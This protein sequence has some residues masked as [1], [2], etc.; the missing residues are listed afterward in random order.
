MD[1]IDDHHEYCS[2]GYD[3]EDIVITGVA[4]RFPECH[5][6]GELFEGLMNKKQLIVYSDERFEKGAAKLPFSSAGV[7]SGLDKFDADYFCVPYEAVNAFDP[8]TRKVIEISYEAIVDSGFDPTSLRGAK[9]GVYNAT[10]NDDSQ[11]L[12]LSDEKKLT[13]FSWLRCLHANRVSYAFDFLGPS[14]SVDTACSSSAVAIWAA[15]KDLVE[16]RVEAAVVNA[17]QL[18]MN[19]NITLAYLKHGI[20]SPTGCNSMPFDANT[21]GMNRTEAV[22]AIFIQKAKHARRVYA[23]ISSAKFVTSGY[24]PEGISVP[25]Q[26]M[27]IQLSQEILS[28]NGLK[29]DDIDYFEGHGTGS[30]V[31]DPIELNAIAQVYCKNGRKRP[32]YVGSVKSNIGHTEACAGLC[33]IIKTCMALDRGMI[34]PNYKWSTPNSLCQ[35]MVEG[36]VK[37][38]TEPMPVVSQYIPV[39]SFGLAG[40]IVQI[41][42]RQHSKTLEDSPNKKSPLPR[43]LLYSGTVESAVQYVFDYVKDNPNLPDEFFALLHKLSFCPTLLKPIRGYA[44]YKDQSN[45]VTSM[46]LCLPNKR[47]VWYIYTG[48]GCQWQGMGLQLMVFDA[49]AKSLRR[50][51]E[52]LKP[53]GIDLFKDL[54]PDTNEMEISRRGISPVTSITAIQIAMTDLLTSLGIKPDGIIGHSTGECASA[55]GDGSATLEETLLVAYFR[56]FSAEQSNLEHGAM[57]AV[58]LSW[59]ETMKRCPKD[60]FA[61]CHNAND[62]TTISGAEDAVK[63]FAKKLKEERIFVRVFDSYGC[64]LHCPLI[65]PALKL[66]REKLLQVFTNPK[67]RSSKWISS[68]YPENEWGTEECKYAGADYFT[69][70]M[71][72]PVLFRDAMRKIPSDAI[73]IEIGPHHLLQPIMRRDLGSGSSYIGLMRRNDPDNAKF[74]FEAIGKMYQEGMDPKVENLYPPVQFPVPRGVPLISDLIRWNYSMSFDVPKWSRSAGTSNHIFA[75]DKE[76]SYLMDHFI[77]GR[78]LFPAAGYIYLAWDMLASKLQKN[79]NEMPVIIENF[80]IHRATVITQKSMVKFSFTVFSD[81]GNFEIIESNQLVASGRVY[82]WEKATFLEPEPTYESSTDAVDASDIYNELKMVGYEYKQ[83]FQALSEI[84]L[85]GTQ[86]LL[87]W[88]DRWIPFLDALLLFFGLINNKGD[89]QLP[90]GALSFKIDPRL[91]YEKVDENSEN[92]EIKIPVNYN[93][94][95]KICR[96]AGIEI[97]NLQTDPAPHRPKD[98]QPTLEEYKFIPYISDFTPGKDLESKLLKYMWACNSLIDDIGIKQK[99]DVRSY[100]FNIGSN[101]DFRYDNCRLSAPEQNGLLRCL[102]DI[103]GSSFDLKNKKKE[104]LIQFRKEASRDFLNTIMATEYPLRIMM[105]ILTENTFGKL[106][107]LE[108]NS[109]GFAV[110]LPKIIDL[111]QKYSHM[112]FRSSI[113]IHSASVEVDVNELSASNIHSQPL[114]VL[115]NYAKEK[116]QDVVIGSFLG[117]SLKELQSCVQSLASIVKPEGFVLF[118]VKEK[119]LPAENL[120]L[121]LY[122]EDI[123]IHTR[124]TTE[125]VFQDNNLLVVSKIFDTFSTAVYLLRAP[126]LHPSYKVIKVTEDNKYRWVDDVKKLLAASETELLWLVAE[127]TPVNGIVGMVNC[128]KQEPGGERVKC[129]FISP[130]SGEKKPPA[131]SFDHALY[132]GLLAGNLTMN[133]WRDGSWGSFKHVLLGNQ[134]QRK[135]VDHSYVNCMKYRDLSSFEWIESHV[136][137]AEMKDSKLVHIYYSAL[138]FKDV[139][140]ATGRLSIG[141]SKSINGNGDDSV[142]G[143]E[144]SGKDESGRRVAGVIANRGMATSTSV[145]PSCLIEV[146]HNWSLEEASTVPVVYAT[147]YYALIIRAQLKRGEKVLIHSGTG[148][149]GIAAINIALGLGCEVFTT[150]G[151]DD[152]RKYLRKIFPQ[153]KEE[154]IGCSRNITFENMVMKRTKGK[155]VDVVLNSLAGDKFLASVRCVAKHGRFIEIGKYDL[156]LDRQL[157]LKHFLENI[158]FHGVFLDQLFDRNAH[159]IEVFNQIIQL[160]REG[161]KSGIVKPLDRKVF[162]RNEVEKA[163]KYMAKGIHVGKVVLKIRDEEPDKRAVPKLLTLPAIPNTYFYPAKVYIIIG[164]LGGF[165]VEVTKWIL[166]RGGRNVIL[167]SRYGARTSYQRLCLRR[168]KGMGANVQVLTLNAAIRDEAE[169]LVKEASKVGAVGGIFNSAV[170]LKDAFMETQTPMQFEEVCAPKAIATRYLDEFSRKYC[171]SIDYFVCFSSISCGRGIAGQTNYG[172]A[173]SVMER[174]CERRRQDGLSGLAIQWGIIGEVGG[175]HRHMGD[176][177]MIAGV[178]AQSVK[179]CLDTMDLFCQEDHP[180]VCSYMAAT[181]AVKKGDSVDLMGQITKILG[182]SGEITEVMQQRSLGEMGLDSL[183]AVEFGNLLETHFGSSLSMQEVFKMKFSDLEQLVREAQETAT[184]SVKPSSN[185]VSTTDIKL[186][187]MTINEPVFQLTKFTAGIPVVIVNIGN[188]DVG[189]FSLLTKSF[190]K[191][192]YTLQWTNNIEA[193]NMEELAAYFLK[194]IKPK[195]RGI[196]HLIGY[197]MGS[198]LAIEMAKQDPRSVNTLTLLDG[199]ANLLKVNNNEINCDPEVNSLLKFVAQFS[200]IDNNTLKDELIKAETYEQRVKCVT[201][202]L[203]SIDSMNKDELSDAISQFVQKDKIIQSYIPSGRLQRDILL[204]EDPMK[205]LA[206]DVTKIKRQFSQMVSGKVTVHR[207]I[208]EKDYTNKDSVSKLVKVLCD[209]IF[210]KEIN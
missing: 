44:L 172:Y 64:A 69:H 9:I 128:L 53:F 57:A 146:P 93:Q 2:A 153:V 138:N 198:G 103:A 36:K 136:K 61:A 154:N 62:S 116:D 199:T 188:T 32:M 3:P 203:T 55:Y 204:I 181:T 23:K 92:F 73:T 68:S 96:S 183:L 17:C 108:V 29:P 176:N 133:I 97:I 195:T 194:L 49:Y 40:T 163:F 111:M 162:Q 180:V 8:A 187:S 167:T 86:G 74:F 25:S 50:C 71:I 161:I 78:A 145:H 52:V 118:Y 80:K 1:F 179:S 85:D 16:N 113:L 94:D 148:G 205:T 171:P 37:V 31:G 77:D 156:S 175:V 201:N 208:S 21:D 43:F 47:P 63:N 34:P 193:N 79:F 185:L 91:L 126:G 66:L 143:L 190:E 119:H 209:E 4:G 207:V 155:G 41:L 83:A 169:Q 115:S 54:S 81:S 200:S 28:E 186:P 184:S 13:G 30:H 15:M 20:C 117:G 99:T 39:N 67:E 144:F 26:K 123:P 19:P 100:K 56:C 192:F 132:K 12:T 151:N 182:I 45:P 42:L 104:L 159:N 88:E 147:G 18:D 152:K 122:G 166:N 196:F 174:V 177:A 170:V 7:I 124:L 27:Q 46:K 24:V 197:S 11:L 95:T 112:K 59:E 75:L 6:V 137:Y 89:F 14:Y 135:T 65:K 48:M 142:L 82:E 114:D 105:E 60:V 106:N 160:M 129:I 165:G 109:S 131:F 140:L 84:N 38:V 164:G 110:V 120:L 149:V 139:M 22:A 134:K 102:E 168:W 90:T 178:V 202:F 210:I 33:S 173:N 127:D 150:V 107:A 5:S 70:N 101:H 51:A 58:G 76:D 121:K 35:E 87:K 10:T 72:A 130:K 141:T 158:S 157:G 189:I 206:N 98:D 125:K 191:P